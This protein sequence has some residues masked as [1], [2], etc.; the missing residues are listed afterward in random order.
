MSNKSITM[1]QIRRI[2]QLMSKGSSKR[3][4]S[5]ELHC[6]RHTIDSYV[7]KI[8]Q[9]SLPLN[10]LSG[11]PDAELAKLFYPATALSLPDSRYEYLSTRL[12]YYQSELTRPG[13]TRQ[14][15]WQEYR[16]EVPLGYGYV[17]FCEHTK[18]HLRTNSATMHFEHKAGERV[19]IDFAGKPLYYTDTTSGEIISC[20]VLVCVLPCS[21]YTYVEALRSASQEHLFAALGRCMSYFGGVPENALSDNMKQYV[22][23]SSRYEPVFSELCQQWALH[24]N[25]TLSA[26][27]VGKPKDKP[28]VENMV[29]IS[30]LRI[31]ASIRNDTFYSLAE[32]NQRILIFLNKH[33]RTP[34]QKR[35]YSRTDRFVQ[36]E[37]P[38][39]NALPADP[40]VIKHTAMAKVQKNYHVILGED[41]HQY[42]VPYQ[43]IGKKV[44]LVYDSDN[45]EVF[46][47]LQ[48]I[49]VHTRNYRKHDYTTL[50]EHMPEQHQNYLEAKGWD[51]DYFLN[52]A[53]AIGENAVEITRRILESRSFIEQA[54]RACLGLI[55]LTEQ[56]GAERFENACKRAVPA[57]RVNYGMIS[58]ILKKGLD[59][60]PDDPLSEPQ[61]L[62]NHENI[63]GPQA[64]E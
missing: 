9:T 51:A 58:N 53:K 36:D 23:K 41:Y 17:Q 42:S 11:K 64:F 47:G 25:T 46:M 38:L 22:Q 24:Y 39:L 28:T 32:L 62:F 30:Y 5:R 18:D 52:K 31:Y 57:S 60:Q 26:T 59:K 10:E 43:H 20:P 7:D 34:F 49:A 55:R 45:V 16:D 33:N 44:K 8:L 4:I 35:P 12:D 56:Y 48:R 50:K 54:Y 1:L 21:G 27:R 15:L 61:D 2:I 37:L 63:R 6:G 29:H 40:F 14:K 13:V 19:Q 3:E